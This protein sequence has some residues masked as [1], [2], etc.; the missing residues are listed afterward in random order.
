[1]TAAVI[2]ADAFGP[3]CAAIAWARALGWTDALGDL[4]ERA[5]ASRPMMFLDRWIGPVWRLVYRWAGAEAADS[6]LARRGA[7]TRHRHV[8][9][10][11][12]PP[13]QRGARLD[14]RHMP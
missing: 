11:R 2:L 8:H 12:R 10:S 1:M 4:L 9:R 13:R 14:R 7:P 3:V 5:A 6:A